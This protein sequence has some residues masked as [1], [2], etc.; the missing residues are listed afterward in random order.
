[1]E[2]GESRR[3]RCGQRHVDRVRDARKSTVVSATLRSGTPSRARLVALR[4]IGLHRRGRSRLPAAGAP[5]QLSA[6]SLD[7]LQRRNTR[8]IGEPIRFQSLVELS[9]LFVGDCQ[10]SLLCCD[11]VPEV[12]HQPYSHIQRG[13]TKLHLISPVRTSTGSDISAYSL[14]VY[15]ATKSK[16]SSRLYASMSRA[17]TGPGT[18]SSPFGRPL[19]DRYRHHA[20]ARRG[21]EALV[22]GERI[23]ENRGR[24]RARR[25]LLRP[26][27]RSP[28]RG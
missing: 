13:F 19:M 12:F 21:H 26:R 24:S 27:D 2:T 20:Q 17:V 14:F 5:S 4:T 7:R 25:C 22:A 23:E 3:V 10:S 18:P 1:M 16:S 8:I 15:C 28:S 11:A 6:N 9:S